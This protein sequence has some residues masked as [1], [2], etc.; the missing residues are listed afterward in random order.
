MKRTLKQI[1]T[2]SSCRPD[3]FSVAHHHTRSRRFRINP[4]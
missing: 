1:F 4:S 2:T 3:C